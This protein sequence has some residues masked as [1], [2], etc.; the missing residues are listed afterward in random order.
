MTTPT[1][2]EPS[3]ERKRLLDAVHIQLSS[4]RPSDVLDSIEQV[5]LW[6][7]ENI[8]DREVY[9][10]LL[11]VVKDNHD[12]REQVRL[13]LIEMSQNGS[14]AAQEALAILPSSV[15]DLL[16]DAEDAYYAAEYDKAIKLYR[17]VL[18]MEPDNP[19]A[20]DHLTKAIDK[21]AKAK[22]KQGPG[23]QTALPR[24]AL[25]YYRRARSFI[26]A[27]D[28][29]TAMKLLDAAIEA[30]QARGMNYPDAEQLIDGV[31]DLL[32]ADEFKQKAY[33]FI[34][35]KKWKDALDLIN[36]ALTLDLADETIKKEFQAM[37]A[38]M[39]AEFE[40]QKRGAFGIFSP[41]GK[42]QKA[43]QNAR[44]VIDPHDPLLKIAGKNLIG[45]WLTRV[46]LAIA[47]LVILL[48]IFA[49]TDDI[50][51]NIPLAHP[52]ATTIPSL[53]PTAIESPLVTPFFVRETPT[54]S[55]VTPT[56]MP[57]PTLV[58]ATFTPESIPSLEPKRVGYIIK[59]YVSA[60]DNPDGKLVGNLG[61][62]EIVTILEEKP[63]SG[64][65]WYRCSWE[66]NGQHNEGW[67]LSQYILEG[68]PPPP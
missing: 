55:P 21:L 46:G 37:Q 48:T 16:A 4:Q 44:G 11:N 17:Q 25:Q 41:L 33:H 40:L 1:S 2:N 39:S 45:A 30:A 32:I 8:E 50:F 63:S 59:A 43:I 49:D 56:L 66:G 24:D 6:L 51:K 28:F 67:I 68:L 53:A 31:Q 62:Y 15:Q 23:N 58:V 36:R 54:I 57:T 19:N 9:G 38:I 20:Q 65:I 26:A 61:L 7:R 5:R 42:L 12:L 22:S 18:R 60:W 13:L 52:K 35:K 14:M 27:R 29:L 10:M 64:S 47:T 34:E 3:A